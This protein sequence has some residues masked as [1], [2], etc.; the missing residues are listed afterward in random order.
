MSRPAH[1]IDMAM[2]HGIEA[3]GIKTYAHNIGPRR[4]GRDP[5]RGRGLPAARGT[6]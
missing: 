5:S 4:D 1:D 2:G 6:F 3:A